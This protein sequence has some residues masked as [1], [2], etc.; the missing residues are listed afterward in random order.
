MPF[1][2]GFVGDPSF[3]TPYNMD[4]EFDDLDRRIGK[5][6][7]ILTATEHQIIVGRLA[8]AE[9]ALLRLDFHPLQGT[10]SD[11]LAL[12]HL[13]ISFQINLYKVALAPHKRLPLEIIRQIFL[14]CTPCPVAL[15]PRRSEAPMLLCRVCSA[16][17]TLALHTPELWRDIILYPSDHPNRPRDVALAHSWLSRCSKSLMSLEIWTITPG[18][19]PVSS[20]RNW[21]LD[22]VCDLVIPYSNR[23]RQLHLTLPYQQIKDFLSL[24]PGSLQSLEELSLFSTVDPSSLT[25][26]EP[27]TVFSS[28]PRLRCVSFRFDGVLDLRLLNLP[29]NQ[30]TR[31]SVMTALVPIDVCHSVFR[32]C[33]LLEE[34]SLSTNYIDDSF[35]Y[36]LTPQEPTVLPVL[37]ILDICFVGP[38]HHEFFAPLVLPSLRDLTF[39]S[40][41]GLHWSSSFYASFLNHPTSVLERLSMPDLPGDWINAPNLEF[42]TLFAMTP[43]LQE[44]RLPFH[45]F[46][47]ESTLAKIST[48]ELV[49]CLE[50]LD[51]SAEELGPVLDML[52]AR[53]DGVKHGEHDAHPISALRSVRI[54]CRSP[55][56][57]QSSRLEKLREGGLDILFCVSRFGDEW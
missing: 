50:H 30:L 44:I 40:V 9:I 21:P 20:Y 47:H 32:A 1:R 39:R 8:T 12:M 7:A 10:S 35:A 2:G 56:Q 4:M 27:A 22:P 42:E 25:N 11:A 16:W 37:H 3:E 24:S 45:D 48:G 34:C 52:E 43:S 53:R 36:Q 41:K 29:W 6:N 18:F 23:F 15:P 5:T 14:Y 28:I 13:K 51:L 33:T 19:I 38:N 17:R 54:A 57:R 31:L 55:D 49:P 46:L 26:F